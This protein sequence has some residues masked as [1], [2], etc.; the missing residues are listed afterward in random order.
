[1]SNV[2]YGSGNL[3][4]AICDRCGL[5]Y[6]YT[7]LR[8]D[9]AKPTM[10][11]CSRCWDGNHPIKT[12]KPRDM[13]YAL[14]YPRPD[15]LLQMNWVNANPLRVS[16]NTTQNEA[17]LSAENNNQGFLG[18][19]ADNNLPDPAFVESFNDYVPPSR[20]GNMGSI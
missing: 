13:A 1:M 10:R 4:I 17:V 16:L 15:V 20:G 6:K 8:A 3:A 19:E 9:G 5:K 18:I 7:E 14:R 2:Q 12:W 11:V